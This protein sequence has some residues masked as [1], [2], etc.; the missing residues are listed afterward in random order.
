VDGIERALDS[1]RHGRPAG[2]GT[3]RYFHENFAGSLTKRVLSFATRFEQFADTLAFEV[4]A[5]IV[6]LGFAAVVLWSFDPMLVVV[7]LG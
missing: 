1:E 2:Q 7:L 6:P 4:I 5:S 3:R